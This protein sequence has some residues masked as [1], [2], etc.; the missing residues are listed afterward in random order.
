M[1]LFAAGNTELD[2]LITWI[3][4]ACVVASAVGASV[5]ALLVGG[6]RQW[7][8]L[9]QQQSDEKDERKVERLRLDAEILSRYKDKLDLADRDMD[10]LRKQ[11]A[12]LSLKVDLVE[13][14]NLDLR[15]ENQ[16]LHELNLKYQEDKRRD[17]HEINNLKQH[18]EAMQV[19][20]TALRKQ[21]NS[22]AA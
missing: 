8:K 9:N 6:Y 12:D 1:E 2:A 17:A 7:S 19:E 16:R 20:L 4:W 13:K 21:V 10:Q 18:I 15:S 14:H 3:G 11:I 22:Q 5:V